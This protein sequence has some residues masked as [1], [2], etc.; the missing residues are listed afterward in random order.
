MV[1]EEGFK[2]EMVG[3]E[4]QRER[5]KRGRVRDEMRGAFSSS[6]FGYKG[7]ERGGGNE[8]AQQ[9]YLYLETVRTHRET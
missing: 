2:G 6:S 9:Y 5:E 3:W 4:K 7:D 1:F 8:S